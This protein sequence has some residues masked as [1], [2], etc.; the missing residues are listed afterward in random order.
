MLIF[1]VGGF[2][3]FQSRE[4]AA[5]IRAL[6]EDNSFRQRRALLDKSRR[7][8]KTSSKI[9]NQHKQSSSGLK[10]TASNQNSFGHLASEKHKTSGRLQTKNIRSLC[11]SEKISEDSK[12]RTPDRNRLGSPK[13]GPEIFSSDSQI[14]KSA[15]DSVRVSRADGTLSTRSGLRPA[16]ST[17]SLSVRLFSAV[18]PGNRSLS[19]QNLNVDSWGLTRRPISCHTLETLVPLLETTFCKPVI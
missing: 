10:Q 15:D 8:E 3:F 16:R 4:S 18:V 14:E 9:S 2:F 12:M 1:G 13:A 5:V 7:A 17:G 11:D 6:K 19:T